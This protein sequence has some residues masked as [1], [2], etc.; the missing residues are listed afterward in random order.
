M[1]DTPDDLALPAALA[2][3]AEI[4]FTY[5][6]DEDSDEAVGC[7]FELYPRLEEPSRTAWWLRLWTGNP[8]ADG[9]RFR[10]FGTTG[11]GDYTGFW[12]IRPGTPLTGQ[13]VVHLGSEGDRGVIARDL[14]DLLWLFAAGLGPGEAFDDPARPAEP[15]DGF[16]AIAERHAPGRRR[17]PARIVAD[18]RA[19]F[20]GFSGLI[21]A[22]C[23]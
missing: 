19:E 2:E 15:N 22:M 16:R 4:G 1:S 11:A 17:D 9:S 7:D 23:R 14:G 21:D 5:E 8:E 6:W 3:V 12:L 20:P 13:P 10:F 18:A